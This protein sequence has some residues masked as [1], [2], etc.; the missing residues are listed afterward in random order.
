MGYRQVALALRN[1]QGLC[2]SGKTVL[3]L[4]R[5]EGLRCRDQAEEVQLLQGRSGQ[6]RPQRAG[7]GFSSDAPMRKLVTDITEFHQPW[8]RPICRL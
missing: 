4:M 5:E 6:G 2:I 8:G 3:R 7:Q 1:E